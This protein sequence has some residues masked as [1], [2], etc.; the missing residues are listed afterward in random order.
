[1]NSCELLWAG[2]C[3]SCGLWQASLNQPLTE[4]KEIKYCPNCSIIRFVEVWKWVED[5]PFR[6]DVL[7]FKKEYYLV[8]AEF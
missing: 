5:F 3:C 8:H 6:K 1:M 7:M 4:E 2:A